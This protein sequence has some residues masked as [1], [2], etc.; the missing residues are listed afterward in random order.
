MAAEEL[1]VPPVERVRQHK[2]YGR[3]T[4]VKQLYFQGGG[5]AL[6]TSTRR[7]A[8]SER[9]EQPYQR[10]LK[11]SGDWQPI[12]TG[13]LERPCY[14]SLRNDTQ[15]AVLLSVN[16]MVFG[17]IPVQD[18]LEMLLLDNVLVRGNGKLLLVAYP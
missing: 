15:A 11:L 2:P 5:P 17:A 14:V 13:W 16:E 1:S 6:E 8:W 4:V 12:D 18:S 9:D 3:L 7:S 10:T